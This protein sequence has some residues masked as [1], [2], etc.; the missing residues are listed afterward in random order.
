M[1]A[2]KRGEILFRFA[3][4]VASTR[5]SSPTL[6]VERDGQGARRG[7]RRR[8]G[9]DRHEV[10][11]GRRGPA[12]VRPDD[13]VGAPRQVQHERAP[14]DRRGR[15][16][17]A[18]ELPDRDPVAG[19]SRPRSSA[20]TRSSSSRRPTRRARRALRR[21]ARRGRAPAGVLNIVHGG[22]SE[23]GERLVRT[24]TSR[25]HAHR[26]ARD[27]RQGAANG[28]RQPQAHPPRARRQ[29]RDHRP[30]RRRPR[31]RRRR[32]PLVGV[33]HLGPALHRREPR[34]RPR[35]GLRA[36]AVEARRAR[37]AAA[38]R[39]RAGRTAPTSAR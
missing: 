7:G 37:G 32:D 3:Q 28:R 36:A 5:T 1:P 38:P 10:L 16:D 18:V 26:L 4:L 6:M 29:E 31:P 23:V 12:P 33:R 15:R 13:A 17:H 39:L 35:E 24:R 11:H 22:G 8:P 21:A 25:H 9:S 20:A 19:R 14:A 30:R 2:P 34:D 27:R